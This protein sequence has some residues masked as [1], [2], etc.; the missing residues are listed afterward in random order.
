MNAFS[1]KTS[2]KHA[3]QYQMDAVT[4]NP[5]WR[6]VPESGARSVC[7]TLNLSIDFPRA[8]PDSVFMTETTS[9]EVYHPASIVSAK[10]SV[11]YSQT[12]VTATVRQ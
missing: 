2:S 1:C 12:S 3:T 10:L 4:R 5:V 11:V 6:K 7:L 9:L 8:Q